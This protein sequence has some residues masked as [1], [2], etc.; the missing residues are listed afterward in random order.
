[1]FSASQVALIDVYLHLQG[2]QIQLCAFHLQAS[3]QTL[4]TGKQTTCCSSA[5]D[6]SSCDKDA[7][8]RLGFSAGQVDLSVFHLQPGPT[9]ETAKQVVCFWSAV[10]AAQAIQ[11]KQL[12]LVHFP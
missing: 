5:H 10:F 6:C 7:G 12:M 1:M 3:P 4:P 9:I 2:S 11:L 8:L